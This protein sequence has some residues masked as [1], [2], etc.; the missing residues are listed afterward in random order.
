MSI[1]NRIGIGMLILISFQIFTFYTI[2]KDLL[3]KEIGRNYQSYVLTYENN[4]FRNLGMISSSTLSKKEV[5]ESF[6]EFKPLNL[7][8]CS[9]ISDCTRTLDLDSLYLY[10]C[11]IEIRNPFYINLIKE[12]EYAKQYGASWDSK[13]IWVICKWILIE[14]TNTGIS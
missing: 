3:I 5:L 10:G 4:E 11:D 14:K 2:S 9:S 8:F 6:K 1:I 13:Y 7:T 12:V